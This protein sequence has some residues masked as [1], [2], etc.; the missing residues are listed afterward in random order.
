MNS[1]IDCASRAYNGL[2]DNL[3]NIRSLGTFVN[4]LECFL[5]AK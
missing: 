3:K 2:P 4:K 5:S 1:P